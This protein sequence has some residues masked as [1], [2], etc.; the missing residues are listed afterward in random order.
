MTRQYYTLKEVLDH[1]NEWHYEYW[2]GKVVE[3]D[4]TGFNGF[5]KFLFA[6][7]IGDSTF[8]DVINSEEANIL[9]CEYIV[10]TFCNMCPIYLDND[11]E[12]NSVAIR[13]FARKLVS[14]LTKSYEYYKIML[15]YF[16]QAKNN[17]MDNIKSITESKFNDTPQSSYGTN[18]NWSD[19]NH[20]TNITR[21][22][23]STE[24]G[25][26]ISRLKEIED[27]I[28]DYYEKWLN[29][30]RWLFVYA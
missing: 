21:N 8:T 18:Y 28:T 2:T 13:E 22:E 19:D 20:L 30:F 26:K 23:T 4:E 1:I 15:G 9:W 25:S 3:A 16:N 27:N 11:V 14:I 17:L 10:P 12:L 24:L 29:E 5:Q 6:A 7:G